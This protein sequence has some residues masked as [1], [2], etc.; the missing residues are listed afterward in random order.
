MSR[1]LSSTGEMHLRSAGLRFRV[2]RTLTRIGRT[3]SSE[4][5]GF[6]D[7]VDSTEDAEE[8]W[9]CPSLF[10]GDG[11]GGDAFAI[12]SE[13]EEIGAYEED[14]MVGCPSLSVAT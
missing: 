11:L 6:G 5:L 3:N 14:R 7:T 12:G 8:P 2:N 13:S 4:R 1:K 9:R 10:P